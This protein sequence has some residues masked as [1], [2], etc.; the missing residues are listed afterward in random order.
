VFDRCRT[1]LPELRAGA[2]G[3]GHRFRCH[4]GDDE[5]AR[6]WEEKKATFEVEG[7]AA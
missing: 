4:L 5:R 2:V 6:I 7:S 1:E 3:E